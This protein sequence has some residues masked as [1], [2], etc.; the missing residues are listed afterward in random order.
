M[1]SLIQ[2][3]R[4][5]P[6]SL[7]LL[8]S[9]VPRSSRSKTSPPSFPLADTDNPTAAYAAGLI[10]GEGCIYVTKKRHAR[11]DVGMAESA[12]PLL[13]DLRAMY[14]GLVCQTRK[15]TDRWQAAYMW[16]LQTKDAAA[17]LAQIQPLLR[18]K[19][20]QAAI[21]MEAE[22]LRVSLIPEGKQHAKWTPAAND[23]IHAM[24]MRI[25]HLNRKGPRV[26]TAHPAGV[27]WMSSKTSLEEPSGEPFCG[28]W[29]RSGLT[30]R[31]RAFELP[32]SALRT[33]VIA[34]SPLLGTP[35][36]RDWK[37]EGYSGQLPTDLKMLPTPRTSD[38]NGAGEHGQGGM[39]LRTA[40]KLL[41]TPTEGD[42]KRARNSTAGRNKLPPTGIH[43][44]DTLT[45]I[46]IKWE[47]ALPSGG[48]STSPPS[49]DGKPSTGHR[50]NPSF[51]GWMLGEPTC[52]T[53]RR[54]WSD[55]E[56]E[57]TAHDFLP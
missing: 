18:L 11:V 28:T 24:R 14:G 47:E 19:G 52:R 6:T 17:M 16:T 27:L 12:L 26:A 13:K 39:D 46:T 41:P 5:G 45:D 22:A 36:A 51:V 7:A 33:S 20:E 9:F 1:A 23:E 44:G 42:A 8:A 10:D 43:A 30:W 55:P 34:S 32:T 49:G 40:V 21:V 4:C 3:L 54:G 35:T 56:C 29:P 2:R 25:F 48:A 37:G 57:H 53:C 50:L 15:G 38:Q 31:G